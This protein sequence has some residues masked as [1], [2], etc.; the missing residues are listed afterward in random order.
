MADGFRPG[1]RELKRGLRA[2]GYKPIGISAHPR[3]MQV[4][5]S[6]KALALVI[7]IDSPYT[8][9]LNTITTAKKAAAHKKLKV[10]A[11]TQQREKEALIKA[12]KAGADQ[13]VLRDRVS[14]RGL[15]SRLKALAACNDDSKERWRA[16]DVAVKAAK[17][18]RP[19]AVAQ[20]VL[21]DKI[22]HWASANPLKH[23][24]RQVLK[25]LNEGTA[26]PATLASLVRNDD[27]VAAKLVLAASSPAYKRDNNQVKSSADA[28]RLLGPNVAV[29]VSLVVGVNKYLCTAAAGDDAL[30]GLWGHSLATAI[31]AEDLARYSKW[32]DP[33]QAFAIGLLHDIGRR[34]LA[35]NMLKHYAHVL[36]T[37]AATQSGLC[38]IEKMVV[39]ADH[40]WLGGKLVEGWGLGDVMA[41]V[42]AGH[43]IA[44]TNQDEWRSQTPGL[45]KTLVVADAM[46]T[47]FG[48]EADVL[49][50]IVNVPRWWIAQVTGQLEF[51]EQT[52]AVLKDHI[53]MYAS[54][55]DS[56]LRQPDEWKG[57]P[58]QIVVAGAQ[59]SPIEPLQHVVTH[60]YSDATVRSMENAK[61]DEAATLLL[62]DLRDFAAADVSKGVGTISPAVMGTK[63]PAL[64][65]TNAAPAVIASLLPGHKHVVVAPPLRLG[66]LQTAVESLVIP[67]GGAAAEAPA[68]KAA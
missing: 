3:P 35:D 19:A 61:M 28:M 8:G 32:C 22:R 48:Y 2:A 43:D 29:N 33:G 46:A 13:I 11:M 12:M 45:L 53:A 44:R 10:I 9:G 56:T 31:C 20:N 51:R 16:A 4:L 62:V 5:L 41:K 34:W 49:E 40:A 39:G 65:V 63:W 6:T 42:V 23:A 25:M 66:A 30:P 67:M 47:A 55:S 21:S 15:V 27:Q 50:E 17:S 14:V 38:S 64:V 18:E 54:L 7:D 26:T 52:Y 68:A 57:K 1:R 36:T 59:L 37:D 24:A 60:A 58:A